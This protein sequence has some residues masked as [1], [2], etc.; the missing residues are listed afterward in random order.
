[1]RQP[2]RARPIRTRVTCDA[3]NPQYCAPSVFSY[4]TS[5]FN[6]ADSN[7]SAIWLRKGYLLLD[8]A[9]VSDV[10]GPGVT[11]IT[12]GDYTRANPPLGY[13]GVTSNSI[14]AG[15]T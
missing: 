11:L 8:H 2:L 15:I 6:W 4:Y 10:Q 5:S 1:M 14:F 12:G 7:F 13:W 9:F 3:S